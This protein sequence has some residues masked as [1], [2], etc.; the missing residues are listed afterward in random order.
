MLSKIQ[1]SNLLA[2]ALG[3]FALK[4]GAAL[5]DFLNG[6]MLAKLFGPREFGIYS[7]L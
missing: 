3:G 1:S 7:I 5:L 6:V 2:T 4:I